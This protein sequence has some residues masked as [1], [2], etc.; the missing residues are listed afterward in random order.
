MLL[1][2]FYSWW[3]ILKELVFQHQEA[4]WHQL[5]ILERTNLQCVGAEEAGEAFEAAGYKT[6]GHVKGWL[7]WDGWVG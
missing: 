1:V 6:K 3:V 5:S 2:E 7:G 4:R